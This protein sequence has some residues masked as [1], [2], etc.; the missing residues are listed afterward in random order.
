[1]EQT[2][3]ENTVPKILAR[4]PHSPSAAACHP[5]RRSLMAGG[6]YGDVIAL[7]AEIVVAVVQP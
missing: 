6:M 4:R 7:E 1:M 3:L 5:E 2:G